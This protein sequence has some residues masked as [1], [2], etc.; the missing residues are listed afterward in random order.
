MWVC[1]LAV[2]LF[3]F[4]RAL[5]DKGNDVRG[6]LYICQSAGGLIS[7]GKSLRHV[8]GKPVRRFIVDGGRP[9]FPPALVYEGRLFSG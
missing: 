7:G 8:N 2:L 6:H 1:G 3:E 4:R 9:I 5:L